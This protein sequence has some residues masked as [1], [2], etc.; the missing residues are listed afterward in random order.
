MKAKDTPWQNYLKVG[1]LVSDVEI[2]PTPCGK[3]LVD[4]DHYI[5]IPTEFAF[6]SDQSIYKAY[7]CTMDHGHK[8]NHVALGTEHAHV[9]EENNTKV[10]LAYTR[11]VFAI[12]RQH[13]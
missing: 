5:H 7:H 11:Q 9:I 2:S 6:E 12:K 10:Y 8:G 1:Q 4:K 13:R 3:R